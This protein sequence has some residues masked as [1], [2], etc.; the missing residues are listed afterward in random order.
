[1]SLLMK[2]SF[3]AASF[4]TKGITKLSQ[5]AIDAD[6]D[7]QEKSSPGAIGLDLASNGSGHEVEGKGP[8]NTSGV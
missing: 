6:K 5:L 4:F 1:M 7:W 2:R 3:T 8:A